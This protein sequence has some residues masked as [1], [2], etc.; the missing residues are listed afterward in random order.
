MP[1][2]PPFNEAFET[3][4]LEDVAFE[5]NRPRDGVLDV[6]VLG[7]TPSEPEKIPTVDEDMVVPNKLLLEEGWP[8]KL[9]LGGDWSN[10]LLPESAE[11]EPNRLP[12]GDTVLI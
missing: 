1:N 5:P 12:P 11:F 9:L 3:P 6:S 8:N 2:R 10:A 7:D 4:L